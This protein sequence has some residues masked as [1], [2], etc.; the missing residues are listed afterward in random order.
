MIS[1]VDSSSEQ[2]CDFDKNIDRAIYTRLQSVYLFPLGSLDKDKI[3]PVSTY[4]EMSEKKQSRLITA[5]EADIF[6]GTLGVTIIYPH[7]DN[8]Y[9][10]VIK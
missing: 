2:Q 7:R 5:T 3:P 9:L 4:I 10:G 6:L 8:T 1:I